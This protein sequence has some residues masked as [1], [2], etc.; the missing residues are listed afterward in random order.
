MEVMVSDEKHTNSNKF[1][2]YM[3]T[4][5]DSKKEVNSEEDLRKFAFVISKEY[6]EAYKKKVEKNKKFEVTFDV[7]PIMKENG[8]AETEVSMC[9]TT[10]S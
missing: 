5:D 6:E 9:R 7:E 4:R 1:Y 8:T 2:T 10:E 3:M